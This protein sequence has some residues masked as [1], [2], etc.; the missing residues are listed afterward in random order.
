[1]GRRHRCPW[2]GDLGLRRRRR[3]SNGRGY[4]GNRSEGHRPRRGAIVDHASPH[5]CGIDQSPPIFESG[6]EPSFEIDLPGNV[7]IVGGF[8]YA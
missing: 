4:S 3:G 5:R 6:G 1:M 2:L 8:A 7:E